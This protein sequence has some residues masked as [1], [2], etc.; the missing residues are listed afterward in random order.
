[1]RIVC[2]LICLPMMATAAP[3]LRREGIAS[4][5]DGQVLYREVHWQRGPGDTAERWVEYQCPGGQP[6]ARKRMP[7]STLPQARGYRLEDGRS[8]QRATV[9]VDTTGVRVDWQEDGTQPARSQRLPLPAGAVIDAGFD[10]AV[11]AHWAAL[12]RGERIELPFL[13]PGRQRYY[14]VQVQLRGPLRWQGQ[15][16]QAI[17]VRLG[18]W[19]GA[20]AP[21]LSLVYADAD[22]RL[23]EFRGTSNLRDDEGRYPNVIIRF[24]TPAALRPADAWLEGSGPPLVARCDV[25]GG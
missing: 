1:M 5:A 25:S 22:R 9:A 6:F 16:A 2:L 18:T 7:A 23:L 19:Y 12:M 11:R 21:R 3:L 15:A 4:T 20:L 8:G 14:P 13:V 10:A 17:E 24:A